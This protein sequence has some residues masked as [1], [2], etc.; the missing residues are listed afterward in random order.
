M[1]EDAAFLSHK[2]GIILAAD[3]AE[4]AD[5][6][7]LA[8]LGAEVP[9]VVGLKVGFTLALRHGLGVVVNAVK[10]VS[11]L[12]VIYDHQK[13]AT[14][15]P[16][17]GAPFAAACRAGGVEGVIFFAQAGPRTLEAFVAAAFDHGLSPIV[18]LAMTHPAYLQSEGGFIADDAP[19]RICKIAI[20]MGVRH[21][22]LPGTK[23]DLV[24]RFAGGPLKAVSGAT[25]MMPGIG[26]QGGTIASAFQAA[27]PHGRFAIVGSAIYRAPGPRAAL[28]A[29]AEEVRR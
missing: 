28:L 16:A 29:M 22:V 24:A 26:S 5:V 20:E 11:Q 12:P 19:D 27:A 18:G 10:E 7:R 13:A 6:R 1:S 3:V 25:I 17:M 9:E 4:L 8:E 14:D 23:T 2:T 15:I 21:Y